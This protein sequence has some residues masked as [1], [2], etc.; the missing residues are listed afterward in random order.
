MTQLA[1]LT[2]VRGGKTTKK[3]AV[4]AQRSNNASAPPLPS[5]GIWIRYDTHYGSKT[6]DMGENDALNHRRDNTDLSLS[7]C[8][9]VCLP[10]LCLNH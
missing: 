2:G 4:P 5:P 10:C 1:G 6:Q 7:Q 8:L 9:C 3:T